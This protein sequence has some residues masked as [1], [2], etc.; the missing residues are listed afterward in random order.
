MTIPGQLDLAVEMVE[1]AGHEFALV[2][3]GGEIDLSNFEELGAALSSP[4]CSASAGILLDLRSVEFVDSSGL[5]VM[6]TCA[7]SFGDRFATILT[8]G[9]AVDTLFEMVD[10]R[11]RLNVSATEEEA[12]ER[13][14]A[15]A[16]ASE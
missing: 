13:I 8:D 2:R 1:A 16:D 5:R 10:I 15:G 7:Q 11:E 14:R 6:L 12:L 4:P 9:S 3:A